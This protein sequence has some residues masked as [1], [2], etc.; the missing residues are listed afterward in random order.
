[1]MINHLFYRKRYTL[2][3]L[4]SSSIESRCAHARN[5]PS[6]VFF[7]SL[8]LRSSPRKVITCMPVTLFIE[9]LL[10][11]YS[12]CLYREVLYFLFTQYDNKNKISKGR[13]R[14]RERKMERVSLLYLITLS[15]SVR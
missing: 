15:L 10:I 2:L 7:Y 8:S 1:M 4:F 9:I 5:R 11:L 6:V 12:F 14:D 13:E 3:L